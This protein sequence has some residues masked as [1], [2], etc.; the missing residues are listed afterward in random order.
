MTVGALL[1]RKAQTMDDEE[2]DAFS[3]KIVDLYLDLLHQATGIE[4]LTGFTTEEVMLSLL[5]TNVY[6]FKPGIFSITV[7]VN[8]DPIAVKYRQMVAN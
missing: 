7:D 8:T 4:H 2:L 1:E 6:E 5:C 3:V